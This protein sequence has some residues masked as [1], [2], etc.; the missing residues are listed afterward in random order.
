VPGRPELAIANSTQNI[1]NHG[2]TLA[3]PP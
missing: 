3:T 1:A 2:I